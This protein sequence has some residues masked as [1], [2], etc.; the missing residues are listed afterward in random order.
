MTL[1]AKIQRD[2]LDF[3]EQDPDDLP[4]LV[5]F[6][7]LANSEALS[8]ALTAQSGISL[9]LNVQSFDA[10]E[11]LARR[12][13][14]IADTLILR[15][16]RDWADHSSEFRT[17]PMPIDG[18][19]R[20]GFLHEAMNELK[21]L[22]PSP[23][24]LLYRPTLYWT[25]TTKVLNNGLKVAYAGWDYHPLPSSSLAWIA[26]PG[27]EYLKTGQIVY[28]PFVPPMSTELEFLKS[29]VNLP[30]QFGASSLF[31]RQHE[32][33]NEVELAALLSLKIP[34]LDGIDMHTLS[35]VKEDNR[36]AFRAFGR[37]LL[38]S[39]NGIKAAIHT[40]AFAK[41]VKKIQRDQIDAALSD[42]ERTFQRIE[43]S[44]ALRK[45]GVLT[46]L[47]GLNA[48]ALIGA[49]PVALVT[50]LATAAAALVA[51]RATYLKEIGEVG[52][53]GAYFLWKLKDVQSRKR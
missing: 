3:V 7:Y 2:L 25:S 1:L 8:A 39:L 50:G 52:D 47:L 48:V 10:F 23:L 41:E 20:P 53:K 15:D 31:H 40:E 33:L 18:M 12:L 35:K 16:T 51:E 17:I 49:P 28:A 34:F 45:S 9:I 13:F 29:G 43:R 38:N 26:G 27:R 32:W 21:S 19:Y 24:T 5:E 14:L 46:G 42:V 30:T 6:W 37:S 4:G 22:R 11:V 44:S 36:D